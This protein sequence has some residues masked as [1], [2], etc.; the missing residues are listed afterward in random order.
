MKVWVRVESKPHDL[1]S[2]RGYRVAVLSVWVGFDLNPHPPKTWRVRHP[3]SG[4]TVDGWARINSGR[5]LC[6]PGQRHA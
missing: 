2:D 4:S 3:K 6:G 1:R 5:K